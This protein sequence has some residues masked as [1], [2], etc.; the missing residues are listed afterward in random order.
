MRFEFFGC[1]VIEL[2][3]MAINEPFRELMKKMGLEGLGVAREGPRG[4]EMFY[5]VTKEFWVARTDLKRQ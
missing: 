2:E 4:S 5:S 3:T 1:D